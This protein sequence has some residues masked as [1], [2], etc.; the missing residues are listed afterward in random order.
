MREAFGAEFELT[1]GYL[2]T[3]SIGVPPVFAADA[4]S[5]VVGR[6]RGGRIEAA[7]FDESVASARRD[8]ARLVGVT[9]DRVAAGGSVGQLVGSVA[10]GL[11][12]GSRVLVVRGEFTSV[13]F[14]FAVQHDRGVRVTEVAPERL[15]DALPGHDVV[16]V[17]LVQSGDG[18]VIDPA[19]LR[20][21]AE[22]HGVRV[23]LDVSQAAGWMPLEL[24]W[25]DW[26]VG[27]GYKWLL[28][29]RGV[30]WLAVGP[31]AS[32]P[33]PHGANWYAG[34]DPWQSLYGLP[35]RLADDARSLDSSPD[36]FAQVGA[37][38]ALRWLA[39]LD[40]AAVRDHCLGLAGA[41]CSELGMPEPRSPVVSL[42]TPEAA[43]RLRTA[44]VRCAVRDGRTRVSFHLYNTFEDVRVLLDALRGESRE[45]LR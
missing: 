16:A 18:A 21:L 10:A 37:A 26:V 2:N 7:E 43:S 42:E 36:W 29:P 38:A 8:F 31:R 12:E 25:A 32:R 17:S 23:L 45:R 28:S 20:E 11:P 34:R 6:W 39:G 22:E 41:L 19:R 1:A 4:L 27:C 40:L 9:A 13:V 35:L 33:R 44:G 3:A 5:E 30:A 15:F 14:P 24:D